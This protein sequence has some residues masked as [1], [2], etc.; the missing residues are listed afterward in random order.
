MNDPMLQLIKREIIHIRKDT[1]VGAPGAFN[2]NFDGNAL[3]W[4][5]G[6]LELTAA[7][8]NDQGAGAH[9]IVF[10]GSPTILSGA[11]PLRDAVRFNGVDEFGIIATPLTTQPYTIYLV[12]N[13]VTWVSGDRVFDDGVTL[14]AKVLTQFSV[15]PDVQMFAGTFLPASPNL[16]I[17]TW[18][19]YAI[20]FDGVTSEIRTNLNAAVVGDAGSSDGAGIMLAAKTPGAPANFGNVEM[21]YLILRSGA[22]STAKQDKLI[23]GLE[24][25]CGLTF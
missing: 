4:Y 23:S 14:D 22:D 21:G 16:A 7:G 25:I 9:D 15:T 20:V 12:L 1:F 8:W 6:N 2:P 3:S 5:D 10:T 24:S 11:T 18:G 13:T 17:G 19:V